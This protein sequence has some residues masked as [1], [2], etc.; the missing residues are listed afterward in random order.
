MS[1]HV[2]GTCG[3][4]GG[5]VSLPVAWYGTQRATPTCENCGAKAKVAHGP[6]LPM[7]Q[8]ANEHV[9]EILAAI[10]RARGEQP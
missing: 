9:A 3:N 4:C 7:G 8:P 10:A 2:I 6:T 5:P 1:N